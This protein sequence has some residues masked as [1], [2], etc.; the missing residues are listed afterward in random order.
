MEVPTPV[1]YSSLQRTTEQ[2]VD[3]PVPRRGVPKRT[4]NKIA[5]IPAPRSGVRRL[6]GFPLRQSSTVTSSSLE[7]ISERI[8][9]Q[10]VDPVS[11][12]RLLG[13][14]QGQCSSSSHSPAGVEELDDEPGEGFFSHFSPKSKKCEVGFAL[15][16]E[17]VRRAVFVFSS[18][19]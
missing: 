9:E 18:G 12:G 7:R 1:S 19:S 8:V 15:E 14:L 4:A 10:F 17:S 2:H 13:S 11:S 3:I 6:Q 5:D 16:S